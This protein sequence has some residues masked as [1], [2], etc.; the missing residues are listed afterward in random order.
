M[1]EPHDVPNISTWV[2]SV[3]TVVN[4]IRAAGATDQYILMPGIP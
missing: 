3:Q 4:A 1:N 2:T